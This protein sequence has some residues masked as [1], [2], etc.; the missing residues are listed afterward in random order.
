MFQTECGLRSRKPELALRIHSIH[1][2]Y[3]RSGRMRSAAPFC[4]EQ[5]NACGISIEKKPGEVEKN[6]G[7][8]A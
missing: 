7:C 3:G 6:R 2:K 8:E 4:A 5:A 1:R